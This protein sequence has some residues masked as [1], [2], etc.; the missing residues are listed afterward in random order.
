MEDQELFN[1]IIYIMKYFGSDAG[2]RSNPGSKL[3]SQAKRIV[4]FV[5]QREEANTILNQYK[6]DLIK[7][8]SR[9]S[10]RPN[11]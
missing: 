4:D 11:E 8:V 3:Q 6:F 5:R 9:M 2:E 7:I 1:E 10:P